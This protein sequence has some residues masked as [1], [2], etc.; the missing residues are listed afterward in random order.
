MSQPYFLFIS[1]D[2][3][4]DPLGG[5]QVLPYLVNLSKKGFKIGIVSCEK[6]EN[7]KHQKDAVTSIIKE[8]NINWNYCFYQSGKPFYSQWQNYKAL[9]KIALEQTK[10][11]NNCVLH[12]RSYLPALIGMYA[13]Q[14]HHTGFIFDMRG[15]WAD[16][17]IEG[18][19]WSKSNPVENLL[20]T[21]FKKK[22]KQLFS[23]ADAV[24]SLTHKAKQIVSQWGIETSKITVIP[25]CAD[26]EHFS[27]GNINETKLTTIKS[28]FAQFENKFVLSYV[29]SLGTWYMAKEMLDFFKCLDKK[30]DSVF[31]IITKD[32]PLIITEL[33]KQIGIDTKK[34]NIISANRNDIPYYMSLSN[35]SLFFI[36]PTFSKSASSPTKMGELLAMQIPVITNTGVGDVDEIIR[37]TNCG[38]LINHFEPE[39]YNKA[40]DNLLENNEAYKSKTVATA[41]QYFSLNDGV[42]KYATVYNHFINSNSSF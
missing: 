11:T 22:E 27:A 20:Y 29:G 16:E 17:R 19:I 30:T 12:C 36:K 14:K 37:E 35:A 41:N 9:K 26:L 3:M 2:G 13:K 10:T 18:N 42:K 24:V 8:A 23:K 39:D 5:S 28:Q 4:T 32:D 25:C 38:V 15:F 33:A 6:E 34:I 31:L 1:I 21:F 7:F 40:I